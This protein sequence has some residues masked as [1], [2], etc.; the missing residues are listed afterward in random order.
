MTNKGTYLGK[1]M[2]RILEEACDA[3]TLAEPRLSPQ[4][5]KVVCVV[6]SD[7][8]GDLIEL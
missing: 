4:L 8:L 3:Q 7:A 5:S 2:E 6:G 1:F